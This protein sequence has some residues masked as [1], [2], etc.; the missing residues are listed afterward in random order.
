M[1]QPVEALMA[2]PCSRWDIPSSWQ[3]ALEAARAGGAFLLIGTS[4]SGKSTLAAVLANAAHQAGRTT[5]LVDA[6]VG[7]SSIGPP[8][9]VGMARVTEPF[10]SLDDL[11][12]EAIDFV[13]APSPKGHLLQCATST[14]V[15][16]AAARAAGAET[17]VVDST[18]LIS[19]S[20]ARALKSAK[21]RLLAP[22]F[23]L[24]LQREGEVEHLVA[25]YDARPR[26]RVLRLRTSRAVKQRSRDQ[27]TSRRQIRLGAHFERGRTVQL[28]WR[29]AP[30]ENS[31]W[32]TGEPLEGH[33]RAY[34]E[35]RLACEVLHLERVSDGLFAIVKGRVDPAGLRELSA[36]SEGT[37]RAVDL[38]ALESLLVGLLDERGGTVGLGILEALDFKE[39]AF[40]IFTPVGD[41]R[42]IRGIRLGA[43]RV[44]RDGTELGW[45]QPGA[46]E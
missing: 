42:G 3:P 39:R 36:S 28:S 40:T 17:V 20:F 4:D 44:Q 14:Y 15:M 21:I 27:R 18:G 23:V 43:I 24:A 2:E 22:D 12:V 13:G 46:V 8:T 25:P 19:G 34:A 29:Q 16:T 11:R 30:V 1:Q 45:N 37:A 33:F 10:D 7:Q 5:G 31:P 41:E 26:P 9:C 32:T 38:A 6:D 35:E